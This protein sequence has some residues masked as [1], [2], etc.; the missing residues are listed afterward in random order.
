MDATRAFALMLGVVFHAAWSF[1]PRHTGGP[2]VDHSGIVA[3]DWFFYTSHSFRMQVFF[4]IAGFF[5]RMLYHKRGWAGFAAHRLARIA[6]PF[7]VGWVILCPLVLAMFTWG[8]NASGGNVPPMPLPVLFELMFAKG[9]MF[10]QRTS[11]GV[12][13]LVHLWFLYYLLWVYLVVIVGRAVLT[14]VLPESLGLRRVAD[15]VAAHIAGSPWA[16]VWLTAATGLFLWRMDGWNGVDTPVGT[17]A[18]SGPVV[19]LYGSFFVLGWLWH[20]HA[21][22]LQNLA[23]H[24]KWQLAGGLAVSVACFLGMTRLLDAGYVAGSLFVRYPNLTPNQVADPARFIT[25]LK[26]DG[27]A[28]PSELA[29]LAQHLPAPTRAAIAALSAAPR[30]DAINGVCNAI[31]GVLFNPALFTAGPMPAASPAAPDA[32]RIRA[33]NR[34]KL[35][36]LL[37]GALHRDP[38]TLPAYAVRKLIY[39]LGYALMMWLLALATLGVFQALC[40]GHSAA[41][42][43]L[44]DSAYWVYLAHLPL[45]VALQVWMAAWPIPAI[46]KFPL[47]L[48]IAFAVL[49]ASYHYLVRSTFIGQMLNGQRYPFAPTPFAAVAM[50]PAP[51]LALTTEKTG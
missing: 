4:L 19:L 26:S 45:V 6:V 15:R 21:G 48:A 9:L 11:G 31:N 30:P 24:W 32:P 41:W 3:F 14:R 42:R 20:R 47:L 1:V 8:G 22:L 49:L 29:N 40:A 36:R 7:V 44:A 39:S 25:A 50:P 5:G 34:V 23:R 17:L 2:I 10:V 27:A 18:P 12:F 16:L 43:Y 37:D 46:V 38:V 28:A 51:V 13:S 35:E 33:E